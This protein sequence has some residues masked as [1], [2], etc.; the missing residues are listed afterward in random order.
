[1]SL[2]I[3]NLRKIRKCIYDIYVSKVEK[4]NLKIEKYNN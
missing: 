4:Y 1:M 3:C 2:R